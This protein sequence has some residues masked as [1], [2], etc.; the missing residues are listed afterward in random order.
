[1]FSYAAQKM[2]EY[3]WAFGMHEALDQF[4]T[5]FGPL[6]AAGILAWRD[7]YRLAFAIL[8]IPA[9]IVISLLAFA[10]LTY[11]HPENMNDIPP[12]WK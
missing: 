2:G 1:M 4:G 7:D 11:S 6:A 8:L 5:L 3:G 10:R 12:I 9:L